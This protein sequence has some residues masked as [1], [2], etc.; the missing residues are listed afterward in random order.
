M[1]ICQTMIQSKAAIKS[2]HIQR[3]QIMRGYIVSSQKS[4]VLPINNVVPSY[5]GRI[6]NSTKLIAGMLGQS[7]TM[8]K[9]IQ[10]IV[11]RQRNERQKSYNRTMKIKNKSYKLYKR[12]S[13]IF[14][15][16]Q[17]SQKLSY[18]RCRALYRMRVMR[19]LIE[20]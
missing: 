4:S 20:I 11:E 15:E 10:R 18:M 17:C 14:N 13:I 5:I 12:K 16:G 2:C 9:K 6:S 3:C 19:L 7:L 1:R 8:F